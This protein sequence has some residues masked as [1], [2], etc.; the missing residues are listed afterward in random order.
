MPDETEFIP[1]NPETE[2]SWNQKAG[3]V[4]NPNSPFGKEMAKFQQFPSEWGPPGNPYDPNNIREYPKM[5][6][7]AQ[8]WKGKVV[9]MAPEPDALEYD[10]TGAWERDQERARRFNE[11][12]T[13]TVNNEDEERRL[14][15]DGWRLEPGAAVE[16]GL[17]R[18]KALSTAAAERAHADRNMS[19]P[20]KREVEAVVEARGGLHVAEVPEKP[21]R[22]RGR[23]PGSKNKPKG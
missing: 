16:A 19:E 14:I 22:R 13:R 2:P 12:C 7:Q 17:E 20:A 1:R 10:S 3:L 11:Q 4:R 8:E 21:K 6:Y 9:C 18:Q 23:P 5:L 15:A